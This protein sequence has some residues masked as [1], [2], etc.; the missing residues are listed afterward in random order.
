M[1]SALIQDP[2]RALNERMRA[3]AAANGGAAPDGDWGFGQ[4]A[5]SRLRDPTALPFLTEEAVRTGKIRPN[6]IVRYRGMVQDMYDAEFF[7]AVYEE[8]EEAT[9]EM[10]SAAF[11]PAAAHRARSAGLRPAHRTVAWTG[12]TRLATMMYSELPPPAPGIHARPPPAHLS[13]MRER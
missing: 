12:K 5:R 4:L 3:A 13:Q 10:A 11:S 1:A 2:L 9:G 6:S 8:E 7:D